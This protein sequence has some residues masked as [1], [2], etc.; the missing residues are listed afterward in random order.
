MNG[1]PASNGASLSVTVGTCPVSERWRK[2][3]TWWQPVVWLVRRGQ[4]RHFTAHFVL[5]PAAPYAC[6][7]RRGAVG[8]SRYS[9]GVAMGVASLYVS[10]AHT[11]KT[12]S[13]LH[14]LL[15]FTE[16]IWSW[17]RTT[18]RSGGRLHGAG[19]IGRASSWS[20]PAAR[21][22]RRPPPRCPSSS[23][24]T[25]GEKGVPVASPASLY[26][27]PHPLPENPSHSH[28]D[29]QQRRSPVGLPH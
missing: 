15:S 13:S 19:L 11:A 5:L 27:L 23:M 10:L 8:Y 7:G 25:E 14:L 28:G 21:G 1:G 16:W 18:R 17:R 29:Q 6:G 26:P 24:E 20:G 22:R 2:R 3:E 4:N 9:D 12:L